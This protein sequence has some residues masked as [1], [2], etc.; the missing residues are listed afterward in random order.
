MDP[1]NG[2]ALRSYFVSGGFAFVHSDSS[3]DV[4]AVEAVPLDDL[5]EA[6]VRSGTAE[7]ERELS[8]ASDDKAKAIAQIKLDV[9]KA[10]ASALGASTTH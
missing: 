5:D 10:M 3:A 8:E 9:Y 2:G 6:A 4:S 1:G 7:A